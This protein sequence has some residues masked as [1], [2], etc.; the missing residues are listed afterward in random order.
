MEKLPTASDTIKFVMGSL[1]VSRVTEMKPT[2]PTSQRHHQQRRKR[3]QQHQIMCMGN[4][5]MA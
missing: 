5:S 4:V 2:A 3:L 1:I